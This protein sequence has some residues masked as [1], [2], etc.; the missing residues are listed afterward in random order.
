MRTWQ[1][2]TQLL[3]NFFINLLLFGHVGGGLTNPLGPALP[4]TPPPPLCFPQGLPPPLPS[5]GGRASARRPQSCRCPIGCFSRR[6]SRPLL[7]IGRAAPRGGDSPLPRRALRVPARIPQLERGGQA[8]GDWPAP[9]RPPSPSPS[10]W[11][12]APRGRGRAGARRAAGG[13]A[14]PLRALPAAAPVAAAAAAAGRERAGAGAGGGARGGVGAAMEVCEGGEQP[15]LLLLQWDRKLSELCEPA[16]P[17]ALLGHTVSAQGTGNRGGTGDG[18]RAAGR[19][20]PGGGEPGRCRGEPAVCS[21]PGCSSRC[22]PPAGGC[23]GAGELPSVLISA[24]LIS[25]LNELL[26]LGLTSCLC[27]A[28]WSWQ[29]GAG[30]GGSTRCPV[31][32]ST[33]SN[34]LLFPTFR[35]VLGLRALPCHATRRKQQHHGLASFGSDV[36]PSAWLC[37][38]VV[39]IFWVLI[40]KRRLQ[41]PLGKKKP[42]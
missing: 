7:S 13:A 20:P 17:D 41:R 5:A 21:P 2:S 38:L 24:L 6:S 10:H 23:P 4:L 27:L 19:A 35:G 39:G 32:R 31:G 40:K 8:G 36:L 3:L 9:L 33:A 42:P 16:D 11:L 30:G 28:S 1:H 14:P 37:S 29:R 34:F 12:P 22:C 25:A 15:P 18:G 26:C